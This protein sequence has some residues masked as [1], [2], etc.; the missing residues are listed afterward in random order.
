MDAAGSLKDS[1]PSFGITPSDEATPIVFCALA[2]VT[3][4][5]LLSVPLD[6][7]WGEGWALLLFIHICERGK[8]KGG[9]LGVEHSVHC[10]WRIFI[11]LHCIAFT[12]HSE[13]WPS[14]VTF[15]AERNQTGST[16]M[17]VHE[18]LIRTPTAS[19]RRISPSL[20]LSHRGSHCVLQ[21]QARSKDKRWDRSLLSL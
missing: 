7:G 11:T 18:L 14:L 17:K 3:L 12:L 5:L 1:S 13:Q 6:G 10:I 19:P 16:V 20:F 4:K 21:T 15:K 2:S 8:T 9:H